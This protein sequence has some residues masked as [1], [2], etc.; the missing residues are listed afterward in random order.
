MG[1]NEFNNEIYTHQPMLEIDQCCLNYVESQANETYIVCQ[2]T[3]DSVSCS[4]PYK[5]IY[6]KVASKNKDFIIK[7]RKYKLWLT[8]QTSHILESIYKCL[9]MHY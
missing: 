5:N 2:K 4:K 1:K 9:R 8:E 7:W 6:S 3:H